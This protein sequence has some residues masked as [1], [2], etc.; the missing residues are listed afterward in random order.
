MTVISWKESYGVG[1]DEIDLEHQMFVRLVQKVNASIDD[2]THDRIGRLLYELLKYAEFHF[3]SEENLMRDTQ[4]PEMEAHAAE[5]RKLLSSL[6]HKRSAVIA[7]Q[8]K[9]KEIVPFL[10][11]WFLIHTVEQDRCF[12]QYIPSPTSEN[13][14]LPARTG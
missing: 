7:G 3:V 10:L 2:G 13:V 6:D 9:V 11:D 8:D 12:S 4:Y 14:P 5:H 1:H